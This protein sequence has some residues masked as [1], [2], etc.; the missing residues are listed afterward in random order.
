MAKQSLVWGASATRETRRGFTLIEL[1][2]VIAII[3]LLIGILLPGLGKARDLARALAEQA[4]MDQYHKVSAT[5]YREY[6][7]AVTPG[8]NHWS[9]THWSPGGQFSNIDMTAASPYDPKTRRAYGSSIKTYTLGLWS[10]TGQEFNNFILDKATLRDFRSRQPAGTSQTYGGMTYTYYDAATFPAAVAFHPS[11]GMNTVYVGGDYSFG[12][13]RRNGLPGPNNRAS[14]GDFYVREA[15]TVR[16]PSE[17]IFYAS[18]RGS[19]VR[20]GFWHGYGMSNPDGQPVRPGYFSVKPPRP[21]P[22]GRSGAPAPYSVGGGWTNASNTF[23]R[24]LAPSSWG[25]LDARHFKKVTTVVFDGSV[26]LQ[27]LE[28]LRD[29]RK[30]SNYADRPDWA[31]VPGPG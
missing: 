4:A 19:D 28:A 8:A 29:M 10:F 7:D 21:H 5:Y 2:V 11:F 14:G 12:A 16:Q 24:G 20:E 13:F 27:T 17:L 23:N 18:S 9:W 31:F 15:Y 25:N 26:E 1:L 30:W 3:A 6:R 22:T